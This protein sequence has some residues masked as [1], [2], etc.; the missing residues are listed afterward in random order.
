MKIALD[1][2]GV[3]FDFQKS[4]RICAERVLRK[5]ISEVYD[6]YDLGIRYGLSK[7]DV[8]KVWTVWNGTAGWRRVMP[9][10]PA[11]EVVLMALDFGHEITVVSCLPS[12]QAAQERRE[13]LD[14]WGLKKAQ[15]IPVYDGSKKPIL[16]KLRPHFYADD[17]AFHCLEARDAMVPEIVRI[18]GSDPSPLPDGVTEYPELGLALV[19][20]LRDRVVPLTKHR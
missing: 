11:I 12:T 19:P 17:L 7:A 1:A 20:F 14:R 6:A 9:I 10:V 4:W 15:L 18:R 2:D 3:L 13:S 16:Q 8:H 5:K